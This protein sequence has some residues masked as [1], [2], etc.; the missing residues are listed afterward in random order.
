[1][2]DDLITRR[3]ENDAGLGHAPVEAP[4]D[5]ESADGTST[6][7]SGEAPSDQPAVHTSDE[8]PGTSSAAAASGSSAAASDSDE[9]FPTQ[10]QRDAVVRITAMQPTCTEVQLPGPDACAGGQQVFGS[11]FFLS[12]PKFGACQN[13]RVLLITNHH[14][15]GDAQKVVFEMPS[16]SGKEEYDATV[17]SYIREWDIAVLDITDE[18]RARIEEKLKA[19]GHVGTPSL[20]IA[21]D[22]EP[23]SYVN[24]KVM[25][26][27]YPLATDSLVVSSGRRSGHEI[28]FDMYAYEFDA[29]IS[30][31]SSGGVLAR[32]KDGKVIG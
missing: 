14:V 5:G 1:M 6:S 2:I 24:E 27:T 23:L 12:V 21:L 30:S 16:I 25:S 4:A 29:S 28:V 10:Q 15:V 17:I 31:G 3:K 26:M 13:D 22:S 19:A 18:T 20:E 8:T 32:E 11:G 7:G 9:V